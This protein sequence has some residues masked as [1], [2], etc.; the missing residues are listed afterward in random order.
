[1]TTNNVLTV[2]F[3]PII[4]MITPVSSRLWNPK[5]RVSCHSI[6]EGI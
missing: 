6:D 4:F 2:I 3:L 1:V 5:G